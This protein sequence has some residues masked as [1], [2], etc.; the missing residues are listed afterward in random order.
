[1]GEEY[2]NEHPFICQLA[3]MSC[4]TV[5]GTAFL[6]MVFIAINRYE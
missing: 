3:T 4:V 6:N 1:M 2:F 5:C